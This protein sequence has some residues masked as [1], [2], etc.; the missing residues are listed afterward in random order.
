MLAKWR[1][2]KQLKMI[3][4]D[5]LM[6]KHYNSRTNAEEFL[7]RSCKHWQWSRFRP[8]N[9]F[10]TIDQ[11]REKI[12]SNSTSGAAMPVYYPPQPVLKLRGIAEFRQSTSM[13]LWR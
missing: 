5:D 6:N 10:P 11:L 1:Q 4:L 7:T 3:V 2:T 8:N 12:S 13:H 9:M